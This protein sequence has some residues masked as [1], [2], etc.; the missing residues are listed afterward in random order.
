VV[1]LG[2]FLVSNPI[3]V[4]FAPAP[5]AHRGKLG[6]HGTFGI[7]IHAATFVRRRLMVLDEELIH[8]PRELERIV[9][10]EMFHFVWPKLGN[11]ARRSW[12]ELLRSELQRRARGELGWSA[13]S[14]KRQLAAVDARRRTRRWREYACESFCDS[15][16]WLL[17]EADGHREFTLAQRHRVARRRWFEQTLSDSPISI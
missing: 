5:R 9:I 8:Q 1:G 17:G 7:E 16:A 2:P 11:G 10:H 4:R 6:L 12:E 3:R 15:A 14:R 13:E